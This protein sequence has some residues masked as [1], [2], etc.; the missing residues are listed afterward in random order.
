MKK[1]LDL[2]ERGKSRSMAQAYNPHWNREIVN[3]E[4]PGY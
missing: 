3:S 2:K 1:D 4:L